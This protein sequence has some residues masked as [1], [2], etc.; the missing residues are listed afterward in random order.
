MALWL[1]AGELLWPSSIWRAPAT[2]WPSIQPQD[3]SLLGMKWRDKDYVDMALPFGLCSDP[4]IFTSI[5]DMIEWILTHNYGVDLLRHYLDDFMTLGPPTSLV[6]HYNL[7]ACIRLYS[8][9]GLPLHPLKL[10]GPTTRQSTLGIELDST[11]LQTRL[12][13]EKRDRI[14][15]PL[16]TWSAKCFCKHRE[17]GVPYWSTPPR[18]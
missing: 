11:T 15:A 3:R 8:I 9:L 6:C 2:M 14:I 5:A 18:L 10:E 13:V 4:Y 7:Q 12:P 16:D 17:L 1:G